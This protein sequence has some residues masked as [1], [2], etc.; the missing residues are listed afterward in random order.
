M[1]LCMSSSNKT[2]ISTPRLGKVVSTLDVDWKRAG[3]GRV[4]EEQGTPPGQRSRLCS[5]QTVHLARL[6]QLSFMCTTTGLRVC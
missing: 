2:V 4:A 6:A 3:E 1:C 5:H